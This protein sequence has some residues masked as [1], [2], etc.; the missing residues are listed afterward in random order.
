MAQRKNKAVR[1][2]PPHLDARGDDCDG[3]F[4][5]NERKNSSIGYE[6]KTCERCGKERWTFSPRNTPAHRDEHGKSCSG[7]MVF[8]RERMLS[9]EFHPRACK[10]CG[11]LETYSTN[12]ITVVAKPGADEE[13]L[14]SFA[15]IAVRKAY[16]NTTGV[17]PATRFRIIRDRSNPQR[18]AAEIDVGQ[19]PDPQKF[20][21]DW[22]LQK[23]WAEL[24]DCFF[25]KP[26]AYTRN[27]TR[28][29]PYSK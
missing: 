17:N 23:D 7:E 21:D 6:V 5:F 2:S 28:I 24:I 4:I 8:E 14:R 15:R 1:T 26:I 12:L 27:N 9:W 16:A 10:I 22:I 18:L 20:L 3:S 25:R 19:I 13:A 29:E 11:R